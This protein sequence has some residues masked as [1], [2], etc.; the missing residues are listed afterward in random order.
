MGQWDTKAAD[1]AAPEQLL[2]DPLDAFERA[3]I[4]GE[5]AEGMVKQGDPTILKE[6]PPML[7]NPVQHQRRAKLLRQRAQSAPLAKKHRFLK[8]AGAHAALA[9]AQAQDPNLLPQSK[10]K[11]E[12]STSEASASAMPIASNQL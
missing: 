3:V 1:A 11:P 9:R 12:N 4:Q 8:R 7:F 6:R 5:Q 2:L 10:L